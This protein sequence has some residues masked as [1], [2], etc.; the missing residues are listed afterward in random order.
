M[1]TSIKKG[2]TVELIEVSL[3]ESVDSE[4]IKWSF[5]SGDG[6]YRNIHCSLSDRIDA[7]LLCQCLRKSFSED[8][9]FY[10]IKSVIQLDDNSFRYI[11]NQRGVRSISE[12]NKN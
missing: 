6:V 4:E 7:S 3:I 10:R 9:P 11:I 2:D 8:S 5:N 1:N 12:D